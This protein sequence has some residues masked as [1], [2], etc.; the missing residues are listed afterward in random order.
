LE[1]R[2][3]DTLEVFRSPGFRLLPNT[4]SSYLGSCRYKLPKDLNDGI[5]KKMFARFDELKIGT[6][7]YIGGNDSMDTVNKLNC[8][9]RA[10]NIDMRILGVPK[11]IDNDLMLTDHTP[12]F[13]SAAK[14]VACS[15]R[16]LVLDAEVYNKPS[17]V[18]VEV[19]GRHAG[20]LTAAA[21]LAPKYA[22]DNPCLIYMPEL[23]F[24]TEK[25]LEDVAAKL[26]E[27]TVVVAVVSEGVRLAS[28]KLLCEDDST[29]VDAFGHKSLSGSGRLLESITKDRLKVKCRSI[30][31][32]LLQRSS[33]IHASLVDV[34]EAIEAGRVGV[35]SA[36]AGNTGKMVAFRRKKSDRYEIECLLEDVGVICNM[37]KTIP[38]EWI[39][40]E[41]TFLSKEYFDYATPLLA[42]EPKLEY[43]NGLPLFCYR[44]RR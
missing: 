30:E 35:R 18:L 5:Y 12:G 22:D 38:H 24:S 34:N 44:D 32:S 15:M 42:G 16:E 19:M 7:I 27:K 2:F 31:L 29:A 9:A 10:A 3:V 28:G 33:A 13:G 1:G 23:P 20:W 26:R 25:Y 8:Y 36:L 37:E 40:K 11:T 39:I 41:G 14:Y 17:V 21:A 4:P 6:F 43:E